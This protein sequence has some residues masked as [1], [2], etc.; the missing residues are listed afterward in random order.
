[1]S[2]GNK[3]FHVLSL[4]AGVQSTALYLMF[5]RGEITPQINVAIF[6]DTGDEPASVYKHLDWLLSLNG[7]PIL[8]RSKGRISDDLLRGENSTGGR[9][10]TVPFFTLK[11]DGSVSKTRRQCSKEYKTDVIDRTIR[12][13]L[14]GVPKG[15]RVPKGIMVHQYIG[16]SLDE[17]G[18]AARLQALIRE[19]K[20]PGW[21]YTQMHFP[22]IERFWTRPDCITYLSDKVPHQTPRSS[23]VYCP[24]H[25]D[26]EWHRLKTEEPDEWAKAVALDARIRE[27][28]VIV[29][30]NMDAELFVHQSCVPLP[31]VQLDT[32]PKPR[33]LQLSMS[34]A[35]ECEGVCGV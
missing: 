24:F 18:R 12:Q 13:E 27:A 1:M 32:R 26:A 23:C 19:K 34:F 3:E 20:R 11:H 25:S 28:G 33:D 17:A 5:M 30:R 15:A 22:L 16:I 21:R 7:P 14:L 31:L 8:V 10:A 6:A 9:F 2:S 29:N 35:A 4:G